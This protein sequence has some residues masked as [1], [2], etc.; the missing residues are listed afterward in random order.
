MDPTQRPNVVDGRNSCTS[1]LSIHI[2]ED[3]GKK[4][5]FCAPPGF[6]GMVP[7]SS[8]APASAGASDIDAQ[9]RWVFTVIAS[10][11]ASALIFSWLS[12]PPASGWYES[13]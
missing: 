7:E 5:Q 8:L 12:P 1:P 9:S 2:M 11:T 13:K 10:L 6:T 4:W 3:G